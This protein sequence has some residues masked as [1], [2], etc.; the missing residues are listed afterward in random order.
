MHY[1][2]LGDPAAK[3]AV[4]FV[5]GWSC[6]LTSWRAQVP[7]FEGKAR[8]VLV[9]LP[10]H[11]KSDRPV[12][13]YTTERFASA[14]EAV[15][16][17][18]GVERALLVGHSMG[19]PVIR[20]FARRY[21]QRTLGLVAVDGALRL[22]KMERAQLDAFVSRFASPDFEKALS[23]FVE[24]MFVPTTSETSKAAIR[25][26]TAGAT[27]SVAVSAMKNMFDP[28]GWND[29]P[30]RA[31]LQVLV[32][33]S[34]SWSADYFAFVRTL[35]P[36]A[37]I[38]EIEGSGHFVMIE[39]PAEV[40]ALLLAF[41]SK[42]GAIPMRALRPGRPGDVSSVDAI[43]K[44]VYD[45]IS[46]PA[47]RKRDWDR[48]R[49]LFADGARLI[50]VGSRAAGDWGPRVLDPEE[51]VARASAIFEKEGFYETEAARRVEQFGHVAHVFSTYESRHDAKEKEPFARGI[52]SFQLV[53]DGMRWWVV[54][55]FWEAESETVKIPAD[56]L[57]PR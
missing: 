56:Y 8:M 38:H 28:A 9:D 4:V 6:D 18:A 43:V 49:S 16:R 50:P 21:P 7:A 25:A 40:N 30:I 37:E 2:S 52:N 29:D 53:F 48:F 22:P 20:Q 47:A 33:K 39:K 17:E 55:I 36:A 32:A 12:L 10:G 23:G 41:A 44:A 11:G 15:M 46:G 1:K 26:T 42:T 27:Q 57:P 13:D 5:H 34:P 31:P 51:Y 45:V 54:S 3:T 35:N 24:S 19:T 14:T